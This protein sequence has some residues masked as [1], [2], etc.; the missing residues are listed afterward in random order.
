MKINTLHKQDD[1]Y[2]NILHDIDSP[3]KTIY[4]LGSK[5]TD[6]SPSLAVVGS[7]RPTPYGMEITK[8]LVEELASIGF[9]IISGLA[10]GID[11]IAHLSTL[12][13]KG[14]TIAVMPCGLDR[15]YPSSHLAVAREI[16]ENGGTLISE[17]KEGTPPLKQHF[18][19]RNRLV[20]GL[21]DAVLV[22]EAAEKSGTLIT[23]RFGLEQGKTILS[24][25]GNITSPLSK[26][27]NNLIKSGAQ[28]VTSALDV[29]HAMGLESKNIK[30]QNIE[31]LNG[32]E[33]QIISLLKKG[34]TD[35]D[36]LRIKCELNI[37]EFNSTLTML[38]ITGR[39]TSVGANQW[40]LK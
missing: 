11:G 33:A 10:L 8:H 13:V 5:P 40:I 21:A 25:P 37:N 16:V 12:E 31:A 24:V 35:S 14:R 38:E 27:T 39:I 20:S 19:A 4:Y 3:P 2:P 18:V 22:T 17:Y 36:E 6:L 32:A 34:I 15:I 1:N 9:T 7:R 23:V 30:R 29:L 28:A 26:G